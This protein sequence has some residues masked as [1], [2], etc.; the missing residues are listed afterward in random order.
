MIIFMVY[1][2]HAT[3]IFIYLFEKMDNLKTTLNNGWIWRNPLRTEF[4]S[5]IQ[6]EGAFYPVS[7]LKKLREHCFFLRFQ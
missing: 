5:L 2:L 3:L 7:D 6:L 4:L 1:I